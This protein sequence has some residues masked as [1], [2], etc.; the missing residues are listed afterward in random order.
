MGI[1]SPKRPAQQA[2]ADAD[3]GYLPAGKIYA[4]TACQTLRPQCVIDAE[5]AYYTR[6]NACGGRVKYGWGRT[7][8]AEVQAARDGILGMLGVSSKEYAVAFTL[9]TTYGINLVLHQLP[10]K[11]FARIVTSTI[12]H[13][14][15][16]LPSQAWAQRRSAER[17]VLERGDDGSLT[18]EAAQLKD[19]VVLL[20]TTSNIDGRGLPN[21]KQLASDVHAGGGILLLDAAQTF[22]HGLQS[23]RGVRFDALFGSGH[24]MY[25][26]SLGFV[27]IRRELLRSLDLFLTGGGTVSDVSRDSA[28]SLIADPEREHEVLE[29]GLQ[30]WAGITGL[31]TAIDWLNGWKRAGQTRDAY[32]AALAERL[33][34]GLRGIPKAH[35]VNTT[36]SPIVS[37]WADGMDS[38]RLALFLDE[39]GVMCRS[40]HF[41][42]HYELAHRRKIPPLVRLSLGLHNTPEQV[43]SL[44]GILSRI[45]SI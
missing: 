42:C 18:Y 16:F 34:E 3:F 17:L 11:R 38:H 44:I 35:L 13:N 37:L 8:D 28:A 12:E 45:L 4:D 7:V 36:A 22:A 9:N 39:A 25:G 31:R 15:V 6:N 30:N 43:D 32:E 27:V 21:V 40:G 14:S 26:P 29:L 20:N 24:K 19:A 5:A 41:C 23:L 2:S 1:F 33:F 10:A